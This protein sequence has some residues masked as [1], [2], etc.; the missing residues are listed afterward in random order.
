M[1]LLHVNDVTF[2]LNDVTDKART[3]LSFEG[4]PVIN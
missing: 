4:Y 2:N 1:H 3:R